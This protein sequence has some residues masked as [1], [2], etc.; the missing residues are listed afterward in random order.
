M[1]ARQR[2]CS[3]RCPV[4]LGAV[5]A[6]AE[7]GLPPF[8]PPSRPSWG[9]G[10]CPLFMATKV[11]IRLG[12]KS[13]AERADEAARQNAQAMHKMLAAVKAKLGPADRTQ[14]VGYRLAP[15]FEWDQAARQNRLL[16]YEASNTLRLTVKDPAR[17]A[18]ILDAATQAGANSIEG[19]AW[20]HSDS[21]DAQSKAQVLAFQDAKRQATELALIAGAALGP[22]LS[23]DAAA[24]DAPRPTA[25]AAMALRAAAPAP[26]VEAGEVTVSAR[27]VCSFA[28]APHP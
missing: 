26:P 9:G 12:I 16:G 19:P 15:H 8:P 13:E 18:A 17:L 28:L 23:V 14:T 7:G 1:S 20:S 2:G 5:A 6:A 10:A 27:V 24:G 3:W 22:V 4:G 11:E 25:P 21:A